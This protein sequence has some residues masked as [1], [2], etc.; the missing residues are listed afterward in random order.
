MDFPCVSL[1]DFLLSSLEKY[2]MNERL[3][4][5]IQAF[6]VVLD[7]GLVLLLMCGKV[8]ERPLTASIY[9]DL[10]RK[11]IDKNEVKCPSYFGTNR[12]DT[13]EIQIILHILDFKCLASIMG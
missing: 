13:E 2:R 10:G 8:G 11:T 12:E 9:L 4:Y 5:E 1:G 6:K 7:L 3:F